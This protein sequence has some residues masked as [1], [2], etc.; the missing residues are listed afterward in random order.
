[1]GCWQNTGQVVWILPGLSAK[2]LSLLSLAIYW[3]FFAVCGRIL[4]Q[5]DILE[6]LGFRQLYSRNDQ[7]EKMSSGG[8][9]LQ[10]GYFARMRHPLYFFTLLALFMAPIMS[11]DRLLIFVFSA[12]YL[13]FAIPIEERKLEARFGEAY[14]VYKAKVPAVL[15]R[16]SNW[17]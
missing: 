5:F 10:T 12:S 3:S 1:M 4:S 17:Q 13:Y 14:R 9:V 16:L 8:A 2:V 6:F 15:P 11:L 7:I